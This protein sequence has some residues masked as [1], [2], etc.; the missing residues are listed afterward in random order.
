MHIYYVLM[1]LTTL[2]S[3]EK[4]RY[5]PRVPS[6]Q[7]EFKDVNIE[8]PSTSDQS[9]VWLFGKPSE[10]SRITQKRCRKYWNVFDI[11]MKENWIQVMGSN[12]WLWFV[13]V[14]NSLGNGLHFPVN[15][16]SYNKMM[17]ARMEMTP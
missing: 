4:L 7:I 3:L 2:E 1:N 8:E 13:P 6:N 9:W 15:E 10:K 14:F 12:R 5:R 16:D 17:Q 11:G